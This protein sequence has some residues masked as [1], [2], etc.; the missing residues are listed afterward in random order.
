MSDYQEKF[1]HWY[2]ENSTFWGFGEVIDKQSFNLIPL[3]TLLHLDKNNLKPSAKD[4]LEYILSDSSSQELKMGFWAFS[5]FQDI[6]EISLDDKSPMFNRHYCYYESLVYLHESIISWL[7]QNSLAAITLIRPFLESAILHLYWYLRCKDSNY[8]SYYLWFD[9]KKEKPPFHD[10]LNFIF[11]S[12]PPKDFLSKKRTLL[13]KDL[14]IKAYKAAC[15]YNHVPKID[16][17]IIG[18]TG[19][20]DRNSIHGFYFYLANINMTLRQIIYLYTL[21]Y[22]L[23]LFP[24]DRY[25]KWGFSGP[26]GLFF[27]ERNYSILEDYLGVENI[28]KIK[29]SISDYKYIETLLSWCNN[30]PDITQKEIE[31]SWEEFLEN[32]PNIKENNPEQRK[33]MYLAEIHALGWFTN[34]IHEPFNENEISD[35]QLEKMKKYMNNW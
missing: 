14:I 10:Q 3:E 9:G 17:S 2:T 35:E 6:L 13:I 12:L 29:I 27:D 22:P 19:G 34:Y 20:M 15:A 11:D 7:D 23:S 25:K 31:K 32:K 26:V 33:S 21:V 30:F 4:T 8:K 28:T 5:Q 1:D 18:I 24:I 16:E